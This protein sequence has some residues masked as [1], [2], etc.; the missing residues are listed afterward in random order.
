MSGVFR[1][2]GRGKWHS[3]E[4]LVLAGLCALAIGFG[5]VA[6][7][8]ANGKEGT[9]MVAG[10]GLEGAQIALEGSYF[11]G[12]EFPALRI[13][14][15]LEGRA[16]NTLV[17]R[18]PEVIEATDAD[19]GKVLKFYQ[20][21]RMPEWP[22]DLECEP[23]DRSPAWEG[24]ATALGYAMHF[25][26][27]MVLKSRARV[28]GATVV[29]THALENKTSL[30]LRDLKMWNCVQLIQAPDF[31]DPLMERT[32]VLVDG[33]RQL[34]AG[35]CPGFE[36][37]PKAKA[38]QQRFQAHTRGTPRWFTAT[39]TELPHPGFPDDP[40]QAVVF[41]QVDPS[42]DR[43][44]IATPS[45]DGDWM[46]ATSGDGAKGVWTNPGISCHHADPTA[47][48]CPAGGSAAV[49][50]KVHF[51]PGDADLAPRCEPTAPE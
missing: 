18:F 14:F 16:T 26:N 45:L 47:P 13:H 11:Q 33:R 40:D 30:G 41:W 28:E 25:D 24:D 22:V 20:D 2:G 23:T 48:S 29:L 43:A 31:A 8:G 37:Y 46:I 12:K 19:S 42:I 27:G 50:V 51:V 10:R 49:T 15:T 21:N 17:V 34:M 38:V 1:M 36:P 6:E 9:S 32:S 5:A 4:V 44:V 3:F 7:Q 39:R 35:L